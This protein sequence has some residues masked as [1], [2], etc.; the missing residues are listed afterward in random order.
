MNELH[1]ITICGLFDQIFKKKKNTN[2]E[3][4]VYF[5]GIAFQ[6]SASRVHSVWL[7]NFKIFYQY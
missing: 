5:F 4:K 3:L 2:F 7:V 1:R 6:K